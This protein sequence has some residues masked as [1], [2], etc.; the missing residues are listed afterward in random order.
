MKQPKKLI[1]DVTFDFDKEE[2]K[3]GPHIAYT[4][5]IQGGAASG[6]NS[7]FL[8]KADE[9]SEEVYKA[10][11][12]L[13][14]DE[15]NKDFSL[16]NNKRILIEEAV[17][18]QFADDDEWLWVIDFDSTTVYFS[19][20]KGVYAV[21]YSY[22]ETTG[23]VILARL[24]DKA[25]PLSMFMIKDGDMK[26]S[27]QAEKEIE[28][29]MLNIMEKALSSEDNIE[30]VEAL[31]EL[32]EKAMK[33]EGS[34]ELPASAYAYT[35]DT[36][37]VSTW[38]LRIDDAEHVRAAV[39]ALGE[40]F[41]GNKVSIPS[42]DLPAVKRKVRAAYKKFYPENDVPEVL[43]SLDKTD[44]DPVLESNVNVDKHPDTGINKNQEETMEINIKE[45]LKSEEFTQFL[46]DREAEIKSEV[47]KQADAR[48]KAAED[49]VE[50]VEK[51]AKQDKLARLEKGF[52]KTVET[53]SF[54]KE[55]DR[56]ELVKGLV[57]SHDVAVVIKMLGM[58]E[59][60]QA[61][62]KK[63]KDEFATSEH[64]VDGEVEVEKSAADVDELL[65]SLEAKFEGQDYL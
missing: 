9:V 21:G 49:K 46:A 61:E 32:V 51:A 16:T 17:R 3:C 38:K 54:V 27:E 60:A 31:K 42:E 10:I 62:I 1:K 30:D 64:G 34:E 44:S 57:E 11:E 19:G 50:A 23:E 24:A 26:L 53:L 14:L 63:T 22:D 41:R 13:G 28:S 47:E 40:G 45:L 35:P 39:A 25:I 29:G 65:K 15:V 36:E 48:V 43:K 7:S 37:K 58:L 6:M 18:K 33:K 59:S 5:P 52:T 55:E 12:E 20:R 4:L 8:F 2:T 56:E